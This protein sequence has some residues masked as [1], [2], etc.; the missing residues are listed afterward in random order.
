M[1]F[2][3]ICFSYR[4]E[5]T[6]KEPTTTT[7]QVTFIVNDGLFNSTPAVSFIDIESVNDAPVITL[8][9][10]STVDVIVIYDEG[11][12]ESLVLAPLLEIQGLFVHKI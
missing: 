6:A 10:D 2:I 12:D 11:Q 1:L 5:N 7:R 9:Q 4:Y 8:G 3:F